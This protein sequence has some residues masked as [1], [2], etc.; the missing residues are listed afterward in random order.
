MSSRLR[1]RDETEDVLQ[2][3]LLEIH[4]SLGSFEGR[5]TLLTWMFGIAQRV[6]FRQF[7]RRRVVTLPLEACVGRFEPR[8]DAQTEGQL[9]ARRHLETCAQVLEQDVSSRQREIFDL[10]YGE[11]KRTRVIA[12]ELGK[13]DATVKV[14]LHRTRHAMKRRLGRLAS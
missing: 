12:A 8:R 13:S 14:S 10:Y 11:S 6:I 5:S 1:D 4:R 2:D 3:V 7:R 9:D